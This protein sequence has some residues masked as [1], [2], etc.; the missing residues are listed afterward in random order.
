VVGHANDN[1]SLR[2]GSSSFSPSSP[3][4]SPA[5]APSTSPSS[6]CCCCGLACAR[7]APVAAVG[8][9]A[10]S[11][12]RE[13]SMEGVGGVGGGV[14]RP[15][16]RGLSSASSDAVRALRR[17]DRRRRP[18]LRLRVELG[19]KS[20]TPGSP[21]ALLPLPLLLLLCCVSTC[22]GRRCARRETA[23]VTVV[24]GSVAVSV[25]VAVA[26]AGTAALSPP[27]GDRAWTRGWAAEGAGTDGGD[28]DDDTAT[29]PL[30]GFAPAPPTRAS[31]LLAS[32]DRPCIGCF[33]FLFLFLFLF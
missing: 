20:P 25:A 28:G 9:E 31:L 22:G 23:G 11:E 19:W 21:N 14:V 7:G 4:P 1:P 26:V 5:P 6:C 18:R 3:S 27:D 32:P 15:E 29:S 17:R 2:G 33:L 8:V 16:A 10:A 30:L 13:E 12:L 24:A